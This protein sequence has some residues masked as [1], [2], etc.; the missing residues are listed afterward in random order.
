MF[1][2]H[3]GRHSLHRGW[4][5]KVTIHSVDTAACWARRGLQWGFSFLCCS[6]MDHHLKSLELFTSHFNFFLYRFSSYGNSVEAQ[7][8]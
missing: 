5:T 8:A 2:L 3:A 1:S 4:A 7:T 6:A